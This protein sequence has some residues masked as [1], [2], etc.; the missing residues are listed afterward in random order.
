[1]LSRHCFLD[2]ASTADTTGPDYPEL[3]GKI[4]AHDAVALELVVECFARNPQRFDRA[5]DVAVIATKRL[6]DDIG[7]VAFQALGQRHGGVRLYQGRGRRPRPF[8]QS[9]HETLGEMRQFAHI[10]RPVMVLQMA[11]DRGRNGRHRT[12]EAVSGA[13]AK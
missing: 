8:L 10:A 9:K 6:T 12:P 11:M 13:P 7:L 1:M 4:T 2:R 3:S 5:P